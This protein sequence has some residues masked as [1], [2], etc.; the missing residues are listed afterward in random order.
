MKFKKLTG[1]ILS[2]IMAVPSIAA[3][4]AEENN[5]ITVNLNGV[6]MQFEAEHCLPLF[7]L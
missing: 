3:L 5:K 2:G 4:A 1:I 7:R 6:Q